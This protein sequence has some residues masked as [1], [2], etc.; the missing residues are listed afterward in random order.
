MKD[1]TAKNERLAGSWPA[2]V[3]W[4]VL[5]CV[6]A[7]ASIGWFVLAMRERDNRWVPAEEVKSVK[8]LAEDLKQITGR[9][10]AIERTLTST[11][12]QAMEFNLFKLKG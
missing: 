12:A 6:G 7:L 1:L 2:Q 4:I 11:R 3:P 10:E 9:V 8:Q 5:G